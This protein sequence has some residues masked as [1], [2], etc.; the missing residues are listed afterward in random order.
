MI[1]NRLIRY[2]LIK[3]NIIKTLKNNKKFC[4]SKIFKTIMILKMMN[5]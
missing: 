5:E 2:H 4:L 1:M 3:F